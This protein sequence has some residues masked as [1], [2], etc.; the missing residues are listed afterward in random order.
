MKVFIRVNQFVD[1]WEDIA[2]KFS[3]IVPTGA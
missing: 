2:A 1:G 3:A